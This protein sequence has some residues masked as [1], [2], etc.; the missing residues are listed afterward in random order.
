MQPTG[1]GRAV[2]SGDYLFRVK[3]FGRTIH[4]TTLN[5]KNDIFHY[6]G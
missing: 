3:Q 2:H 5:I 1:H 6:T 4:I